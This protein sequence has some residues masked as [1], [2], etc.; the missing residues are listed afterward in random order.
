MD[1]N[2]V[3]I[4]EAYLEDTKRGRKT[5]MGRA[6]GHASHYLSTLLGEDFYQIEKELAEFKTTL[7]KEAKEK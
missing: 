2:L 1:P 6:I 3:K 7:L 5:N 4:K